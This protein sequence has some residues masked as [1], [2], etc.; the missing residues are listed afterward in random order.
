MTPIL[1]KNEPLNSVY[2][3]LGIVNSVLSIGCITLSGLAIRWKFKR[4]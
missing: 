2:V 1:D 3:F 4:G